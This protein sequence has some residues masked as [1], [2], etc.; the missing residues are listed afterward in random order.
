MAPRDQQRDKRRHRFGV[1]KRWGEEMGLH[2][3]DGHQ[4][5]AQSEG[6]SL[7]PAD[8][9]QERPDEAGARGDRHSVNVL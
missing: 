4:W 3:M 1:F 2:V 7:R 8:T 5:P 6:G 9:Y